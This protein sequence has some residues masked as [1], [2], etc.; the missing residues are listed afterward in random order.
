MSAAVSYQRDL[1]RDLGAWAAGPDANRRLAWV[2]PNYWPEH[3]LLITIPAGRLTLAHVVRAIRLVEAAW[4]T[5]GHVAVDVRRSE[6]ILAVHGSLRR[7][8]DRDDD[9]SERW[10]DAGYLPPRAP[11][12]LMEPA[13][14][15]AFEA[16]DTCPF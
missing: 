3:D 13:E 1:A 16:D 6:S 2:A 10:A 12:Q 7:L 11:P 5:V 9:L 15:D 8:D 4:R 14:L